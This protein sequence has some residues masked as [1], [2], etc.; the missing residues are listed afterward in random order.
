MYSNERHLFVVSKIE[1]IKE[2]E[3]WKN[4][5]LEKLKGK[6]QL[7]LADPP[8]NCLKED[9][10]THKYTLAHTYTPLALLCL[11]IISL[12]FADVFV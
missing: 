9:V 1:N 12:L 4:H 6:V 7:L 3:G 2:S 8:F 11:L 5:E 10:S